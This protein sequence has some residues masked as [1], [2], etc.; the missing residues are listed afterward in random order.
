MKLIKP[1]LQKRQLEFIPALFLLLWGIWV[2]LPW[3]TFSVSGAYAI[4]LSLAPEWTWG[5][6]VASIGA[7]QLVALFTSKLRLRLFATL[8]NLFACISLLLLYG[9]GDY[10]STGIIN[11]FVFAVASWVSYLEILSDIKEEG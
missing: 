8:L 3:N 5:L 9:F 4:M 2:F 6:A 11:M 1:T 10:R 7:F